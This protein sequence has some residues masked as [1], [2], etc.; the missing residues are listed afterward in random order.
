M[1]AHELLDRYGAGR[2]DFR[3]VE[4]RG[5]DLSEAQL[6]GGEFRQRGS[7]G[8]AALWRRPFKDRLSS[9][10]SGTREPRRRGPQAG[11]AQLDDPGGRGCFAMRICT[12]ARILRERICFRPTCPAPCCRMRCLRDANLSE[13]D[14]M[15]A[16]LFGAD[17]ADVDLSGARL[18]RACPQKLQSLQCGPAAGRFAVGH[19]ARNRHHRDRFE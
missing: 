17:L 16:N 3:G 5:A 7:D 1:D 2:R 10:E 6:C 11:R 12:P 19:S 8:N 15:D 18:Y 13:A 9:G 4:L 14:L